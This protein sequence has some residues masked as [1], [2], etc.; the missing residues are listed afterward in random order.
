MPIAKMDASTP[1]SF[2]N[3][4]RYLLTRIENGLIAKM[5]ALIVEINVVAGG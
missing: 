2:I 3:P 4:G 5:D 1:E